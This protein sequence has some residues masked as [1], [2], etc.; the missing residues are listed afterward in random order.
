MTWSWKKGEV[1]EAVVAQAQFSCYMAFEI[2]EH[3]DMSKCTSAWVKWATLHIII[4]ED[5][6]SEKHYEVE[7]SGEGDVDY[8][9]PTHFCL[10]DENHD[11]VVE[12]Y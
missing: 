9:H 1:S 4:E 12:D 8:K 11:A 10:L 6:G 2:P 3:I 7:C 5:D